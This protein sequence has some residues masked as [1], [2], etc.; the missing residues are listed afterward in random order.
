MATSDPRGAGPAA[1]AGAS[2]SIPELIGDLVRDIGELVRSEGRLMRAEL[3]EAGERMAAGAEMIGAGA[4]I[5]LV[6][7]LVLVQAVVIALAEWV[8]PGFAALIVGGVLAILGAVLIALG[9]KDLSASSLVPER[10]IEQT[11]RDARLAREKL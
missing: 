2:R 1:G 6:A 5:L 9:R 8:G 11:S 3:R 10:T 7:L 4:V